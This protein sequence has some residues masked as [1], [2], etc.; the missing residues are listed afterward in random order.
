MKKPMATAPAEGGGAGKKP[1]KDSPRRLRPIFKTLNSRVRFVVGLS[2]GLMAAMG[3]IAV[4]SAWYALRPPEAAVAGGGIRAFFARAGYAAADIA[5]T[6]PME[7]GL[8][9]LLVA[10]AAWLMVTLGDILIT[11][12]TKKLMHSMNDVLMGERQPGTVAVG[13]GE[14]EDITAFFNVLSDELRLANET[15]DKRVKERTSVLEFSKTMAEIQKARIEAL[16]VSIGEGVVAIDKV[17]KILLL[18]AIAEGAL[19]WRSDKVTDVPV[20]SAFQM[21]DEKEKVVRQEAWPI[22]E[23]INGRKTVTTPAPNKPFYLRRKDGG[24][25]PVKMT[26]SPVITGE[27]VIGAIVTFADIT[28]EVEFD[29]RKSEF[30]SIASHELRSPS[31]AIRFMA[32]MLSKGNFGQLNEKQQEW[33][34][35][36]RVAT[37]NLSELVEQLLNISRIEAGVKLTPRENDAAAFLDDLARQSEAVLMQKKQ[38]MSLKRGDL[39]KLVFDSF[40][41]GEVLKNFIS[42]A[43]KYSPEGAE[44]V[45]SAVHG[46]N[47]IVFAV[48]DKGMGIPKADH[49]RM[50]SKFFRASNAMDSQ[51]RGTGLGLYFCRTAVEKHGGRIG[52]DSE[53]GKGSTF[54]FTLPTKSPL[55]EAVPR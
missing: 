20:Y 48:T 33:A 53:E 24:R 52:F 21:E 30:I 31:T 27:G 51:I 42:N 46:G 37:D 15:M 18:N 17:G 11:R 28:D 7:L 1:S 23:A 22:W 45:L 35:K 49:G 36:L 9:I 44:V 43:S 5:A 55:Q 41:I 32:D 50:F 13:L 34:D 29:R 14:F 2:A 40:M 54:W 12:R 10:V 16:V 38:T 8:S 3:F 6:Y 25:F 19:W 39:P 4:T 26:V 47:E